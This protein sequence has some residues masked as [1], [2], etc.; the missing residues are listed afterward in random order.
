MEQQPTRSEILRE[1]LKDLDITIYSTS[2]SGVVRRTDDSLTHESYGLSGSGGSVVVTSSDPAGYLYGML[3]LQRLALSDSERLQCIIRGELTID[4][5][6]AFE[7]RAYMLDVSRNRVPN[8]D[9]LRL[10][11]RILAHLRFNQLQLYTEHTFAYPGHEKVWEGY[12]P[13]NAEEIRELDR[14][15]SDHA[16]ELVPNQNSLG[17]LERWLEHEEYRYLAEAPKGYL[18]PWGT[19]QP[20]GS[21]LCPSIPESLDFLKGL[22]DAL[23]PNFTSRSFHIGCDETFDIGLGRSADRLAE[24]GGDSG[25]LYREMVNRICEEVLLRGRLPMIWGDMLERRPDLVKSLQPGVTVICWW[26]E[27]DGS[28]SDRVS[29]FSEAGIP[30]I[31]ACGT[32]SWMSLTGRWDN[33]KRNITEAVCSAAERDSL[34]CMITDWG[35]HGHWNPLVLT[36]LPLAYAGRAF[37]EGAG[38]ILD[39]ELVEDTLKSIPGL[40]MTEPL[41]DALVSMGR[42]NGNLPFTLHN[43]TPWQSVLIQR[44]CP[45]YMNDLLAHASQLQE[46]DWGALLDQVDL[47]TKRLEQEYVRITY[48]PGVSSPNNRM[49]IEQTLWCLSMA[50]LGLSVC[51]VMQQERTWELAQVIERIPASLSDRLDALVES[52]RTLWPQQSRD[53]GLERTIHGISTIFSGR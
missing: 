13:F 52:L 3:H 38:T 29:V 21:S 4:E 48:Q 46:V 37:W 36:L 25:K 49:L 43:T 10:L 5:K 44:V 19:F 50:R 20:V 27:G 41:L 22:Y 11:I 9:T 24:L 34:G 30:T 28:L 51:R 7:V 32:S 31:A 26:Y 40:D 6:P 45:D 35:D 16:I 39:D 47:I 1:N 8:L 2:V 23:L 14:F 42:L 53:G 17:H 18:N 12:S 15:C 33:A